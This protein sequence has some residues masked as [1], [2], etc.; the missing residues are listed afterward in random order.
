MRVNREGWVYLTVIVCEERGSWGGHGELVPRQLTIHGYGSGTTI[1][2]LLVTMDYSVL[3]RL[4]LA[5][6]GGGGPDVVI[7]NFT[8]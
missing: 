6:G 5:G 1:A 8:R 2:S 7:T 4:M 3:T